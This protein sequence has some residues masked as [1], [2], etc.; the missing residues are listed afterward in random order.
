MNVV[1]PEKVGGDPR[2][3]V[4]VSL[5]FFVGISF[6]K[7]HLTNAEDARRKC[8]CDIL[9]ARVSSVARQAKLM[10]LADWPRRE[11]LDT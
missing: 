2:A 1:K 8:R 6:N 5:Y 4:H 7:D 3:A 9:L 10:P 11:S